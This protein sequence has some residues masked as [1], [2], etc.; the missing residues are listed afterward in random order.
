M[1][2]N[3]RLAKVAAEKE[4]QEAQARIDVQQQLAAAQSQV[5][6]DQCCCHDC[7]AH[8]RCPITAG[9]GNKHDVSSQMQQ[10]TRLLSAARQ[11]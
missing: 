5:H 7:I 1:F 4:L 9:S 3:H 2:V 11:T 8:M 10:T 6:A